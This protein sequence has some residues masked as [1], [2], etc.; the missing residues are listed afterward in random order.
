MRKVVVVFVSLLVGVAFAGVAGAAG[1]RITEEQSIVVLEH[2]V[3]AR[4]V[5]EAP[6]E[7]A[8]GD[9][10]LFRSRLTDPETGE[11]TGVLFVQCLVQFSGQ[12]QC[13]QI[14]TLEGGTIVAGGLIPADQLHVGGS[15]VLAISGGTGQFDNA[16][17]S[18]TVEIINDAGDSQHS[19][20]AI[21]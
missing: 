15:W 5:D 1:P 13:D 10:Y 7:F 6:G 3:K 2:T 21:P 17:G 14:Y 4:T 16:R 12:D 18:V 9:E 20:H 19:I 8:P 11:K